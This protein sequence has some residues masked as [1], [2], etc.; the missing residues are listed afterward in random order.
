MNITSRISALTVVAA[1]ATC[2]QAMDT[3]LQRG[4]LV[5]GGER[6]TKT[7]SFSMQGDLANKGM[8][9]GWVLL[10]DATARLKATG[11]FFGF[12]LTAYGQFAAGQDKGAVQWD[13]SPANT[14]IDAT[15]PTYVGNDIK[16]GEVVSLTFKADYLIEIEGVYPDNGPFLQIIPHVEF[17]TYPYQSA[18]DLKDKQR[19]AGADL[20]W[21]T[22]LSGVELGLNSDWNF[23]LPG[24]RGAAGLREFYQ[25]A[26]FD[27]SF[28]QVVNWGNSA[29]HN[30]FF[31]TDSAGLTYSEV[32]AKAT[33]PLPWIDWWI[34]G[35]ANWTYWLRKKDR[36]AI[37]DLLRDVGE[38]Q[39]SVGIEYLPR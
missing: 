10:E 21:A 33:V 36:E 11:R 3:D 2:V 32:G 25:T 6:E 34:Y 17:T 7:W 19:W 23:G 16:P 8:D 26:P 18:N 22:P 27:L 38:L 31:K 15:G 5:L 1:A 20:W 35:G 24:Y 12:G 4:G 30:Y 13:K 39:F 28:W 14:T 29:Y 37:G 9:Q